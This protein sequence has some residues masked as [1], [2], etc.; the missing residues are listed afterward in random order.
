MCVAGRREL[1]RAA[2]VIEILCA[3]V[4]VQ[5]R[6]QLLGSNQSGVAGY[7]AGLPCWNS[8]WS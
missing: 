3:I 7:A 1:S 4:F 8:W 5:R 6:R 2:P